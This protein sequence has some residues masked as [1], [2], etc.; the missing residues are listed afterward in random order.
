VAPDDDDPSHDSG[1]IG[2]AGTGR[3]LTP[4][5]LATR[6][7]LVEHAAEV[8]AA[9]GYASASV[10]D[11][12]QRSGVSSGAIYGT[13][14]GKADL[15]AEAVTEAIAEGLER[16]PADV[17]DLDLPEIDAYQFATRARGSREHMRRLLLEAAVAARQDAEVRERLGPVLNERLGG[18]TAAYAEW[19]ADHTAV[20]P[21][22]LVSLLFAAELGLGV[23]SELGVELPAP[24]QLADL[25]RT[26]L[27]AI[28]AD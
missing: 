28:V 6:A 16:L 14:R 17:L 22:A 1:S 2:V 27:E 4:K 5:A 7:R 15:L 9:R 23:L 8:F 24:E 26:V 3:R 19:S 20:D 10:R 25:V 18:W 21:R 11:I 13:F 12:A